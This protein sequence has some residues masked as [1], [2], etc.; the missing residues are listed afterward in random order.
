MRGHLESHG[1]AKIAAVLCSAVLSLGVAHADDS[2]RHFDGTWDT[3]LSCTNAYGALGYSF[4]FVSTVKDGVLHGE[5]GDKG[6]PGWLQLDGEILA[7]GA[8]NLYVQ[9]LVGAAPFAV[10]Q[11]PAGSAYGYHLD[12]KFSGA[13]G[14][15]TRVE[16]RP[17]TATFTRR[18]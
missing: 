1:A 15:G 12:S 18:E 2:K 5:K 16:G 13:S 9:G 7:D 8:A 11:R 6:N 3:I 10:G 14:K 4:E 17:C